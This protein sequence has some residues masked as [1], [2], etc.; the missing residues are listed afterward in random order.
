M[1]RFVAGRIAAAAAIVLIVATASFLLLHAAP[2]GPFDTDARRSPEAQQAIE[3]RYGLRDPVIVQ[4]ARYLGGLA[5]GDLGV[6][7]RRDRPVTQLIADHGPTSAVLGLAALVFAV[8][9]GVALGAAAAWRRD[10][11]IDRGL[12]VIALAGISVPAFVL[13]PL[14]VVVVALELG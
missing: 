7:L 13:G 8:L 4:Y 14:L 9:G 10:T 12:M 6:S 1:L 11:W 3:E 5:R 2:G